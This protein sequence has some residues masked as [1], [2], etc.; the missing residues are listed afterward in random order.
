[1][2]MINED[3]QDIRFKIPYAWYIT[4]GIISFLPEIIIGVL[5]NPS[6]P[7]RGE[8]RLPDLSWDVHVLSLGLSLIWPGILLHFLWNYF[9]RTVSID[10]KGLALKFFGKTI[11]SLSW[12]TVSSIRV[13][14]F[15]R[16]T[17]ILEISSSNGSRI[18]VPHYPEVIDRIRPKLPG[19]LD[20]MIEISKYS[21]VAR[22]AIHAV[23]FLS[24]TT[25][26]AVTILAPFRDIFM[27][28][29]AL[30]GSAATI[31]FARLLGADVNSLIK[32]SEN[33]EIGITPLSTAV[34]AGRREIAK[35]LIDLGAQVD[36]RDTVRGRTPLF[37]AVKN[38]DTEMVEL[39]LSKGA[40]VR[41]RD[42][43]GQAP[44]ELALEVGCEECLNLLKRAR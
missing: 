2:F 27:L 1:M 3:G 12:S 32:R 6:S 4:L 42:R 34:L 35:Y 19:N 23:A 5:P 37:Y 7:T 15:L 25:I 10:D 40:D 24:V 43:S 41:I 44:E 13:R 26:V 28:V 39:L 22:K 29:G 36:R 20:R 38:K 18:R 30:N 9:F 16:P 8:I 11:E 31:N 21:Y 17:P 33:S 14:Y